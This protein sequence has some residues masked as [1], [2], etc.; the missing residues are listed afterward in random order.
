MGDD[1]R[2]KEADYEHCRFDD[3]AVVLNAGR[4]P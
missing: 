4:I 1:G 3:R 2:D